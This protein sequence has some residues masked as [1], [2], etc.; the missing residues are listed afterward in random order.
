M[1][2]DVAMNFTDIR[3]TRFFVALLF[4][5]GISSGNA[6]AE[7]CQTTSPDALCSNGEQA[8]Y[9]YF[10]DGGS[11][12]WLVYIHGGG[13]AANAGIAWKYI[14]DRRTRIIS[15]RESPWSPTFGTGVSTPW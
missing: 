1:T 7:L 8:T 11:N 5:F 12:D 14:P 15:A 2:K 4:A 13:V 10:D 9:A 6:A 3:M